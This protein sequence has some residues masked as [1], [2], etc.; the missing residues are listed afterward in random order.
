MQ[1]PGGICEL[2]STIVGTTVTPQS[3]S[4][5]QRNQTIN[6]QA[7]GLFADPKNLV[8]RDGNPTVAQQLGFPLLWPM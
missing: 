2:H 1:S 4:S 6:R 7:E 8:H 5:K 3:S